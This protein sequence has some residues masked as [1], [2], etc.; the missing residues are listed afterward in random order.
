[1]RSGHGPDEGAVIGNLELAAGP[2]LLVVHPELGEEA[3]VVG[4][5][6]ADGAP[7]GHAPTGSVA[8]S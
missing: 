3:P 1:V 4:S 6:R 5:A 7:A 8:S 2:V